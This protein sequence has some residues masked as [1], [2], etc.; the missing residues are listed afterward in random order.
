MSPGLVDKRPGYE[1]YQELVLEFAELRVGVLCLHLLELPPQALDGYLC[2]SNLDYLHESIMDK[3]I[4]PLCVEGG[5]RGGGGGGEE[6]EEEGGGGG[7]EERRARRR[8]FSTCNLSLRKISK[9]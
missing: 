1:S 8:G 2:V 9:K 3:D 7:G 4:L 5:R 6:G